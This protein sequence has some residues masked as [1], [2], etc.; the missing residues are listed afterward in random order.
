MG[1]EF[2]L[3]NRPDE[4]RI[5]CPFCLGKI[6]EVDTKFK[7]YVNES[8]GSFKCFRCTT[9]GSTDRLRSFVQFGGTQVAVTL[10]KLK[11]RVSTLF[12]NPT[13][14]IIDLDTISWPLTPE[15][16]IAWN[17]MTEVR[18]FTEEEIYRYDLR[19]GREYIEGDKPTKRWAGRV[20]FPFVED[21]KV[22]FAV[23][24]SYTNKD[25]RYL[26]ST[27][28]KNWVVYGYDMIQNEAILCEGI[29][30]AIAAERHTGIP[31][32]SVL[33]KTI[34]EF[35]VSKLKNKCSKVY[36][37]LDGSI[38]VTRQQ[39]DKLNRDLLRAGFEVHEV[40][41]PSGDPDEMIKEEFIKSFEKAR[42][43]II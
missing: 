10:S 33:G 19:V 43:I 36:V 15:R 6:G 5:N 27:G 7:L 28:S 17:Y 16:K 8:K 34:T 3:T 26:N 22:V 38:D 35:Q 20:I 14:T 21:G 25:P 32:I 31:A 1:T 41:L 39:R 37:C 9:A 23:G 11:G 40:L 24:R 13:P 4:Q 18:K 29:I 42:R 30:S 2:K 12:Q